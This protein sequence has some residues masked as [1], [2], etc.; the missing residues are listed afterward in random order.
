MNNNTILKPKTIKFE[1]ILT[2]KHYLVK[3]IYK[4]VLLNTLLI[5]EQTI[6]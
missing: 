4:N 1:N 2:K 6:T 5:I 3:K